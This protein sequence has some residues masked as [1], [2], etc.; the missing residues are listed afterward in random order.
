MPD[1]RFLNYQDLEQIR[2]E[3]GTPSYVYDE[4]LLR[5]KAQELC[6]FPHA[7]FPR[8]TT[9]PAGAILRIFNSEGLGIDGHFEVERAIRAGFGTEFISLMLRNSLTTFASGHRIA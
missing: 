9:A 7:S 1:I 3:F 5:K 6:A 4:L 2:I 8:A